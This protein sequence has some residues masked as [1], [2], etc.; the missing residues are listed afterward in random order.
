MQMVKNTTILF[1]PSY[2]STKYRKNIKKKSPK[3]ASAY[4][5]VPLVLSGDLLLKVVAIFVDKPQ[6]N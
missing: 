4:R 3:R 1:D 2:V 5:G 6:P